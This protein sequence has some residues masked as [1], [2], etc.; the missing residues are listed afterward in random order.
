M[1]GG[2]G[3]VSGVG[4]MSIHKSKGLEFP[5][6]ILADLDHAFSRQDFDTPVLV[7]PQMGLGPKRVDLD[8]KIKYPT[9]A[10]E[11]I[12][13]TLRRENL[14]EELRVLYVAMTRPKEKLILVDSMYHAAGRLQKLASVASCPVPPETVATC[15]NFGEW[16][17]LPL[18]CRSEA[19]CLRQL[20]QSAVQKLYTDDTAPWQVFI[21]DAQTFAAAPRPGAVPGAAQEA[22][23]RET[24]FDPQLLERVYP[25]ARET[26]L[27]SKVTA[28]QLKGRALDQEIAENAA[29][30]PYLRPLSQPRFRQKEAGLTP[31]EQ[32]TATHLALQYLDFSDNDVPG[33]LERL[34][35]RQLLSPEQAAAVD[36]AALERFLQSSLAGEIRAGNNVLREYRFTLLMDASFYDPAA[37][38]GDEMLLQGVVDCCFET[39]QGITVV[40]FKTDRVFR[41]EDLA[42]RA[43]EYRPQL[44]AYSRALALV[45]EKPVVR[46][47]LYFL[48]PGREVELRPRGEE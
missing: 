33:Q 29:H 23:G 41:E 18:L 11:A 48:A 22:Q 39:E 36:I 46:R 2:T 44:E 25:Y 35:A 34:T 1:T 20:G 40:D 8:R 16:L 24:A 6:V 5:I 32:G 15:S 17:L 43:E 45:L 19:Q 28:T 13:G 47:V 3:S 30:T 31:A 7:H 9:L 27:P 38:S 12:A 37:S 21:H 42:R 4:L 10:R 14:S 26:V